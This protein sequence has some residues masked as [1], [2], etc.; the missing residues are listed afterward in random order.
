MIEIESEQFEK[1]KLRNK[2]TSP[3]TMMA[4]MVLAVP[5]SV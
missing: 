5:R 3:P 1:A 2:S 4:V